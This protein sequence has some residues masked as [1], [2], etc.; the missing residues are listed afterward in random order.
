MKKIVVFVFNVLVPLCA[1]SH[2]FWLKSSD[3]EVSLCGGHNFPECEF[4]PSPKIKVE[5]YILGKEGKILNMKREGNKLISK[6][7]VKNENVS[8][9]FLRGK[10]IV[11]CGIVLKKRGTEEIDL[12]KL[13]GVQK[14]MEV[15]VKESSLSVKIQDYQVPVV[16]KR[17]GKKDIYI[18][19]NKGLVSMKLHKDGDVLFVFSLGKGIPLSIHPEI[20]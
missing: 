13:C 12:S 15:H 2:D 1:Y 4:L 3:N 19:P 16:V 20:K 11:Y 9:K 6:L 10:K 17:K 14:N 18:Y 8:F 5:V 7:S